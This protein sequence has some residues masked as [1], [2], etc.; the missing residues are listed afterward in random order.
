[1]CQILVVEDHDLYR[2]LLRD[3]LDNECDSAIIV[4]AK[5]GSEAIQKIQ[6]TN[7]H[8]VFMNIVL[9]DTNGLELMRKI[10]GL[11]PAAKVV[12]LVDFDIP[13]YEEAAIRY[14]A[15]HVLVKTS[16]C[17]SKIKTAVR[18]IPSC[19]LDN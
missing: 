5:N 18:S 15:D 14:G 19:I 1:M 11:F 4:E 7:P 17:L 8:L 10:K 3:A 6:G 12:V 13:E 2:K 16:P 9:P